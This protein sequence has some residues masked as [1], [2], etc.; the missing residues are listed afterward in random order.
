MPAEP[1]PAPAPAPESA[2]APSRLNTSFTLDLSACDL[3]E[4]AACDLMDVMFEDAVDSYH[5]HNAA[6]VLENLSRVR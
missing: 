6:Q 1:A 5:Q 3:G 2:P 4:V